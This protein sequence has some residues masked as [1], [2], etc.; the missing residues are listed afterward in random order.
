MNASV[1][2]VSELLC[3][4]PV[5]L[6]LL[7]LFGYVAASCGRWPRGRGGCARLMTSCVRGEGLGAGCDWCGCTSRERVTGQA[8]GGL[9][10]VVGPWWP[11]VV[12]RLVCVRSYEAGSSRAFNCFSC[13]C[14]FIVRLV[15]V[16]R[17]EQ[18]RRHNSIIALSATRLSRGGHSGSGSLHSGSPPRVATGVAFRVCAWARPATGPRDSS[19]ACRR[20]SRPASRRRSTAAAPARISAGSARARV[21]RRACGACL[22]QR[23][24]QTNPNYAHTANLKDFTLQDVVHRLKCLV[25]DFL[26]AESTTRCLALT[27]EKWAGYSLNQ[28][29]LG[30][31]YVIWKQDEQANSRGARSRPTASN[32]RPR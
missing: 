19:W 5:H 26:G 31:F 27:R 15:C 11:A 28:G 1:F 13:W 4:S 2:L 29:R 9:A 6:L 10:R 3:L 24:H 32:R 20:G 25:H 30:K 16:R 12:A 14:L 23:P 17:E 18:P 7:S 22:L 8:G 21:R